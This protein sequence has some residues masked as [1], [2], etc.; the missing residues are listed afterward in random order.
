MLKMFLDGGD[1]IINIL[2]I[3]AGGQLAAHAL[4]DLDLVDGARLASAVF[5]VNLDFFTRTGS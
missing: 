1:E 2:S 5:S 4:D 3:A